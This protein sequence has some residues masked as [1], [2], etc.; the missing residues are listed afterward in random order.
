[1]SYK[2]R[3]L[4]HK[5]NKKVVV[6]IIKQTYCLKR[7]ENTKKVDPK[8]LETKSGRLMLSSKCAIC[9]SKKSRFMTE[10]EGER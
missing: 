4:K 2:S 9:G 6:S 8:I 10:Q 5:Y 3:F 1:M 7:K